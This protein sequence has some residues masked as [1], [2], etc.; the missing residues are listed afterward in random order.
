VAAIAGIFTSPGRK[1][2]RSVSHERLRAIQGQGME[3]CAHANPPKREVLFA[4]LQHLD[5]VGVEPGAIRENL[6]VAGADVQAWPVGQ[7]VRVGEA[8]FEITMVCD[9]CQRMDDLRQ[10]LRA[11]LEEKR[12][13][14]ARVVESGEVALGDEVVLL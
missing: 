4:S 11:E 2:G 13:M 1:S 6:T 12:G 14:L 9:P 5:S 8:V 7:R 10:G 3:G